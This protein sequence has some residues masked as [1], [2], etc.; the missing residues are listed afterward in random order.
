MTADVF[1][2]R[3]AKVRQRFVSTLEAKIEE[4]S[5]ALPAL[6]GAATHAAAA[7]ADAYMRIHGIVGIGRTVGFPDTG[8][9]AHAV[10]D[11]LR[12]PYRTGRG[13]VAD[14]ISLLREALQTLRAVAAR[15]LQAL[16]KHPSE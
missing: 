15:E 6:G 2:D 8:R 4:T 14:E 10:E 3:L 16:Q 11:V 9:A 13:L 5:A 7:V 12:Q 1:V